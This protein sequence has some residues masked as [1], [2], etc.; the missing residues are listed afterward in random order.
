[1]WNP[2]EMLKET[3]H[4]QDPILSWGSAVPVPA[5]VSVPVSVRNCCFEYFDQ[6]HYYYYFP[7]SYYFDFPVHWRIY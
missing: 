6:Y 4:Q 3:Q 1:M 5:P 7:Y 2:K